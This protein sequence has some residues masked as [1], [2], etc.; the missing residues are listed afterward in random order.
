MEAHL[1]LGNVLFWRGDCVSARAHLE[2]VNALYDPQQH[3][4]HT[5]LYGLDPGV[6][7]LSYAAQVLWLL[8]Y[9]DQALRRNHEALTLAHELGHPHTLAHALGFAASLYQFRRD[10]QAA[11]EQVKAMLALSS[12]QEFPQWLAWGAILHGWVL[13][14]QGHRVE[15]MAQMRQGLTAF[16]D[17]GAALGRPYWLALLAE[18][19]GN[20]WQVEE[21]LR[22]LA[23]ALVVVHNS[24]EY[25][26]EAE[27]LRLKGYLLQRQATGRGGL[28]TT[29]PK[30]LMVRKAELPS[31]TMPETCFWQALAIACRRHAKSL[32]L[33]AA[34]SLSR[35][36]QQQGKRDEAHAL[37]API[38]GWFT[39]GFD[40]A[41]LQ[42]AKALLDE[43]S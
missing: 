10:A 12:A 1:A 5:F 31:L 20:G 28:R 4:S 40:T 9:P 25:R 16:D 38:Y 26:W 34:M 22:L 29:S 30:T 27:L 18:A 19:Y 13:A 32:E 14:E 17:I 24:G 41:D 33:R 21:G 35:L 43:L 11:K 2:R 37:L 39:E 7:G 6:V 42:E 23:E 15:G 8:G 3:R 36:W